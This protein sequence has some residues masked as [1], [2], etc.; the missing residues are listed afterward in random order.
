MLKVLTVTHLFSFG[1][2]DLVLLM[3][4]QQERYNV[5]PVL[6]QLTS[7]L[8]SNRRQGQYLKN[9]SDKSYLSIG[10]LRNRSRGSITG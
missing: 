2:R 9:T 7:R 4:A 5:K 3:E 6:W 1:R 10:L 8:Q